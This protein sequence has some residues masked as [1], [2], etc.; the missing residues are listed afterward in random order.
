VISVFIANILLCTF[1]IVETP[2]NVNSNSFAMLNYQYVFYAVGA[3]SAIHLKK[4]VETPNKLRSIIGASVL[5]ALCITFAIPNVEKEVIMSHTFRLVFCVCLWFA[6]DLIKE[7]KAL[8]FMKMSFFIYCSHLIILQCVQAIIE[9]V[10]NKFLTHDSL[11]FVLEWFLLPV[12][13]IAGIVSVG[14]FMKRFLPKTWN[15]VTGKRV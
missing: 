10:T 1:G 6:F 9:V 2:I 3:Y 12:V 4:F 13:L 15:I 8:G 14:Y 7:I 5:I 11:L